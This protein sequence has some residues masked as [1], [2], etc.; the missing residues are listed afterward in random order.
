MGWGIEQCFELSDDVKIVSWYA[1]N[2]WNRQE[3][4]DVAFFNTEY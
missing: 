4:G 1:A 2:F 3:V